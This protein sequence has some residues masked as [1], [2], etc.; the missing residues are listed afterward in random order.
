MAKKIA[1]IIIAII[2]FMFCFPAVFIVVGSITAKSELQMNFAAVLQ[3]TA[4]AYAKWTP[5]PDAPSLR[6]YIEVFFDRPEYFIMFW[7]SVKIVFAVLL[8]Q[9]IFGVSAAWGF[10]RYNFTLKNSLFCIYIIL[11][12]LPFQVLMLSEYLV[13]DKMHIINTLWAIILP[14]AFSTFTVFIVYN[15]F[16]KIPDSIIE[17]ARL[18]GA[19]EFR[20][21]VKIGLPLGMPGIVAALILSAFEYW[22]VIEQ[23][24]VFLKDQSLW[25]LSLYLPSISLENAGQAFVSSM[26]SLVPPLLIFVYGREHLEKGIAAT[27]VK[28]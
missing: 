19:S 8:G 17:A 12:M 2:A 28:G 16:R 25:P 13:L 4:S 24:M 14:G 9:L 5:L 27:A 6:S 11:M 3:H 20:I 26:I 18:D 21:F 1:L 7:N 22:A 23:P 10:A 15:F